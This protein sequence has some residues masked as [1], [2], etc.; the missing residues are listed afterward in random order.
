MGLQYKAVRWNIPVL[1]STQDGDQSSHHGRECS[2]TVG[3]NDRGIDP[4][5]ANGRGARAVERGHG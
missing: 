2:R 1:R 5:Q 3:F 4:A